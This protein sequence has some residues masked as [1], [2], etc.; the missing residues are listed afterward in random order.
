MNRTRCVKSS[1]NR[2]PVDRPGLL[3][4]VRLHPASRLSATLALLSYILI[5]IAPLWVPA[6]QQ[7][8]IAICTGNGIRIIPAGDFPLSDAP[9][10]QEQTQKDCPL[11]RIQTT[12]VLLPV[13]FSFQAVV[14]SASAF[15]PP[16]P[17]D[18]ITG[19]CA[20]FDHHSRAPPLLA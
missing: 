18:T 12:H 11:C 14:V 10:E 5:A 2:R 4:A 20:G 13:E 6:V 7:G 15:G 1:K 9:V 8:G 19:L 16:N 17:S 3:R